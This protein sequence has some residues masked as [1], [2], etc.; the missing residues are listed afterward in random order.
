MSDVEQMGTIE[1]DKFTQ[2]KANFPAIKAPRWHDDTIIIQAKVG[3]HNKI[4]CTYVRGDG[5]LMFPDPLYI[6]GIKAKQYKAFNMAT[7]SGGT[8]RMRAIPVDQFKRLII[9]ERSIHNVW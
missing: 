8:I 3:P 4:Y 6:S 5:S 2:F 1:L 9:S 7:A